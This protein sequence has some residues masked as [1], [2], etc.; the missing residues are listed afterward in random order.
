MRMCYPNHRLI[1]SV[2]IVFMLAIS[3][4]PNYASISEAQSSVVKLNW[5]VFSDITNM[6]NFAYSVCETGS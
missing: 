1:A 3:L 5:K 2:A 4:L 6:D